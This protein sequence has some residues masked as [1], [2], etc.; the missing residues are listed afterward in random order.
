VQQLF[1]EGLV[2]KPVPG[3]QV[4]RERYIGH[5]QARS[6]VNAVFRAIDPILIVIPFEQHLYA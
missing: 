4:L 1:D 6:K 2:G 5:G 3:C